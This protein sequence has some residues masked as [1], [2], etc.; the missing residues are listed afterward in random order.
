[1]QNYQLI[2]Q[3]AARSNDLPRQPLPTTT[4]DFI[5]CPCC[6]LYTRM[7]SY[8][9]MVVAQL[10]LAGG[11]ELNPGP[12]VQHRGDVTFGCINIHSAVN[13]A[14]LVHTAIADHTS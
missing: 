14:A 5:P 2:R 10:L 13:R 1:M 11:V 3:T 6:S 8:S 12:A 4:L 7:L 9:T